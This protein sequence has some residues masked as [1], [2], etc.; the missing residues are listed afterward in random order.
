MAGKRS[1]STAAGGKGKVDGRSIFERLHIIE[2]TDEE[3]G[4][5]TPPSAPPA[6]GSLTT[7]APTIMAGVVVGSVD[8]SVLE[9]MRADVLK[10][11]PVAFQAFLEKWKSLG[12]MTNSVERIK[13]AAATC[14]YPP[15]QILQGVQGRMAELERLVQVFN[16]DVEKARRDQLGGKDTAIQQIDTQIGDRRKRTDEQIELLQKQ[17]DQLRTTTETEVATLT[18][19]KTTLQTDRTQLEQKI[20]A[21]V[22][23]FAAT[24]NELHRELNVQTAEF[25]AAL[26]G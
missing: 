24:S 20:T 18:Q 2:R 22:A 9:H 26:S 6:A 4:T 8:A 19:Q 25:T 16:S 1:A 21:T 7:S 11:T 10:G 13:A 12:F 17:I 23:T 14:G 15:A 5:P 3:S